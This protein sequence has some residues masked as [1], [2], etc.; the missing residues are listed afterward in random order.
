KASAIDPAIIRFADPDCGRCYTRGHIARMAWLAEMIVQGFWEGAVEAAYRKWGWVG[1][2]VALL[3][4]FVVG[5]LLLW[6]FFG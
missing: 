3:G 4:P 1:G 2:A 6:I 5:G